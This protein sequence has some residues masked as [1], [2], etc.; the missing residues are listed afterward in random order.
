MSDLLPPRIGVDLGGTKI[1]AIVMQGN[2]DI[3]HRKRCSTPSGNYE[4][5]VSAIIELVGDI[6][7]EA[8]LPKDLPIGIGTPGAISLKSGLMMN[9]NSTCLNGKPLLEDLIAASG[10]RIRIANDA[11]CFALSEA[12][13][14]AAKD[15]ALM[16]GV[17]MGT[18]VG[19]GIVIDQGLTHGVNA[20]RGE[21]G[22]NS[23]PAQVLQRPIP[24][25]ISAAHHVC[26]CGRN[27]CVE[28]WIAGPSFERHYQLLTGTHK[29]AAEIMSEFRSGDST[30]V[31]L[32]DLQL[33][34][35]AL[36]LSNLVNILDPD[37]IVLG[38]GLSNIPEWYTRLPELMPQY[39]FSDVFNTQIQ[40]AEHGDSGGVRG[41]AW[42]WQH[43][44]V[45]RMLEE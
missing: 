43:E 41:A 23:L 26:F 39:V 38:G 2:G 44:E 34:L 35:T 32:F 21:W 5:T 27:D 42:L 37:A 13:D 30:A 1:E 40:Q 16:V 20:I 18:G 12:S 11:D 7:S 45:K 6:C 3:S 22:H 15:A 14:G 4:H 36:A 8:N 29:T 9:C 28:T 31:D 17:I 10:R 25:E 33:H 24:I 19:G